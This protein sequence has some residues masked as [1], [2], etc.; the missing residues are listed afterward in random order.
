[1]SD[2]K[3]V[4]PTCSFRSTPFA[5]TS[6]IADTYFHRLSDLSGDIEVVEMTVYVDDMRAPYRGMKMCH[7]MADERDEL[8]QMA[9]D[10]GVD[11]KWLQAVGTYREHFDIA[12]SKRKLAVELGA[13]EV[14]RR[15]IGAY[16]ILRR[17]N[18]NQKTLYHAAGIWAGVQKRLVTNECS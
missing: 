15:E 16:C 2:E 6:G 10:I 13:V 9:A 14:T 18:S 4:F 17:N 5:D 7:M 11:W 12:L 1:M 8:L 3:L